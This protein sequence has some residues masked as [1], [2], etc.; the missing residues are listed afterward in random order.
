MSSITFE[1][2][3]PPKEILSYWMGRLYKKKLTTTLGG[4]LS[5]IDDDGTLY[6]TPSGSDKAIISPENVAYRK[7][8]SYKFEGPLKPSM[9]WLL[10]TLIYNKR[11]DVRGVLHAHSMSLIAFSLHDNLQV[12]DTSCHLGAWQSCGKVSFVPYVIPGSAD[13]ASKAAEALIDSDCVILQNHG[14]VTVG[15]TLRQAYD[16]FITLEYM[17]RSFE[18]SAVLGVP[19]PLPDFVLNPKIVNK[20][21][22]G[23]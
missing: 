23:K 18:Y 20:K 4:N 21:L 22:K 7:P 17:A 10:H 19:R 6:I 13:L 5:L 9:E 1:A 2:V 11:K 3:T 14:V 8:N 15:K 16:R 12:P